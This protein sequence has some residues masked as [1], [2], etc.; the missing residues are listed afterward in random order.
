M[1]NRFPTLA[2]LLRSD[3][4]GLLLAS[5]FLD[6]SREFTLS[7]LA[8]RSGMSVA[9]VMRDVDRLLESEYLTERRVGR[10]RLVRVNQE[11]SLFKPLSEIVLHAY[12][13]EVVIHSLLKNVSNISKA[14][15]F[16]SWAERITGTAGPNPQDIDLILIGEPSMREVSKFVEK[17]NALLGR[18]VNEQIISEGEWRDAK[19]AFLKTIKSRPLVEIDTEKSASP[20][21]S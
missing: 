11:H 12:G 17:A 7:E 1:K 21:I 15:I 2:P 5:L 20:R 8:T 18:E 13:P 16:G 9:S 10:S 6:P 3:S 4:Q 14:F 19:S